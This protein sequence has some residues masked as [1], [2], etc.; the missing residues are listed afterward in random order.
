MNGEILTYMVKR[1]RQTGSSQSPWRRGIV[2]FASIVL[3]A[4]LATAAVVSTHK[5]RILWRLIAAAY[6]SAPTASS[7]AGQTITLPPGSRLP[8]EQECAARIHRA[9]WEPR[10]DNTRANQRVP[11]RRQIAQLAPWGPD[12]GLDKRADTLRVQITGNFKGTTDEILRWAACK[13]GI[14]ANIVRAEAIVESDWQQNQT[15]DYTSNRGLCPPGTWDGQGCYQS[16]GLLQI[17]YIDN[18]S[19]WPMSR[20]DTAFNVEYTYAVIRACYEG[21]TTYLEKRI[22]LAGYPRYHAGDIWGCLGC[23]YSGDWYDQGAV[24]YIRAVKK[25]LARRGWLQKGF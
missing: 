20:D 18:Q 13:W 11:T 15:S 14:N 8:G 6:L 25:A 7:I 19:A 3:I 2:L 21:W 1:S 12:S 4:V 10:P 16:Y 9:S 22:P 24:R 23:W 5:P 17:K